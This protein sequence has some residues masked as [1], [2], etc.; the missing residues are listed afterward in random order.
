METP[1]SKYLCNMI[2]LSRHIELL[3]LKHNCVIVP[4]LGGFVTQYV[5][6]RRVA[7]EQLFLPPYRSVGFNS[8]LN[9]ND[10]LLVQSYMQAYDTTYPET[11]KLIDD[12]VRQ[13]KAELQEKGEY[14]LHGIGKIVWG[15]GGRYDFVPCEAGVP[16]P[17]LY[18]FDSFLLKERISASGQEA[19]EAPVA[20]KPKKALIKRTEKEITISISRELLNYVAAAVVA[21]VFYFSWATPVTAPGGNGLPMNAGILN[22]QIFSLSQQQLQPPPVAAPVIAEESKK[23]ERRIPETQVSEKA[24]VPAEYETLKEEEQGRFSIVLVSAV[25][26]RNAEKYVTE[27]K[28]KGWADTGIHTRGRMVRV[29]YGSYLSEAEAATALRA[30]RAKPE[31]AEAWVMKTE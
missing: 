24:E 5:P 30:M 17:E 10:G 2:E 28:A 7:E 31:F 4:G 25:P 9:I 1:K 29:V 14:S 12:A 3:L 19:T 26:R 23:A 27:M 11:I 16:S 15:H 20:V 8:Q 13:I 6:A 22:E 21:I 18:G